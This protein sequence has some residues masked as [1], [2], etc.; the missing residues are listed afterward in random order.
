MTTSCTNRSRTRKSPTTDRRKTITVA[1]L[2]TRHRIWSKRQPDVDVYDYRVATRALFQL[3]GCLD[4]N[5]IDS[6]ILDECRQSLA[7]D[8]LCMRQID[9]Y[10]D[11]VASVWRWG[12]ERGLVTA[13]SLKRIRGGHD[14]RIDA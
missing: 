6:T 7:D 13:A 5:A 2:V 9:H 12:L 14:L 4:A 3:Y 8:G 11:L 1:E 10:M